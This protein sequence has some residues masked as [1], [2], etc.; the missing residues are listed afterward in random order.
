MMAVGGMAVAGG[1]VGGLAGAAAWE[2]RDEIGQLV[3]GGVEDIQQWGG[4]AVQDVQEWGGGAMATAGDWG[5]K[6]TYI[7]VLSLLRTHI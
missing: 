3:G 7:V 4:G 5:G 1:V 2:N 6:G